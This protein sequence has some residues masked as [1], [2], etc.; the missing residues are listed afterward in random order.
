MNSNQP[1]GVIE[2]RNYL[3]KPFVRDQFIKYFETHFIE[4]Q[5]A[6]GAQLFGQFR[7]EAQDDRFSWIRGFTNMSERANFLPAFYGGKVWEEFG[8]AA[9]DMMLEWHHVHLLKPIPPKNID[10]SVHTTIESDRLKRKKTFRRIDLYFAKDNAADQLISFFQETPSN[11]KSSAHST[12][13]ITESASNDFTRLP[14][15]QDPN[16]VVV[17]SDYDVETDDEFH[18]GLSENVPVSLINRH[19]TLKL[20]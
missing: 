5:Q 13:W 8:P 16:L 9:N 20:F 7:I 17:I 11:N 10:L 15:I 18:R 1:I 14:V 6:L 12:Y 19:E 3:L 2:L 4:S